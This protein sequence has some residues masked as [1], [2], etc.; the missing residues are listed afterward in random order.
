[1]VIRPSHTT[2][3]TVPLDRVFGEL[4]SETQVMHLVGER[5]LFRAL[6]VVVEIVYV[7]VAVAE[8]LARSEVEVAHHLVDTDA[9]LN[10]ASLFP[11]LVKVFRV[12][13]AR[14]LFHVLAATEGP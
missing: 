9:T 4:R 13:L 12:V 2:L 14:A 10:T 3:S 5:V 7:H 6:E 8:T 1:M 11:L